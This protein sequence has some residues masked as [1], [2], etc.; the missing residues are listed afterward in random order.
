MTRSYL[1]FILIILNVFPASGQN[2]I[3]NPDFEENDGC[4]IYLSLIYEDTNP[5]LLEWFRATDGTPDHFNECADGFFLETVA[6]PENMFS[7]YQPTHSGDAYVGVVVDYETTDYREYIQGKLTDTLIAGEYYYFNGWLAPAMRVVE[8]G[9]ITKMMTSDAMGVYFSNNRITDFEEYD[10]IGVD[11]HI[12]NAAGNF[13][14]DPGAWT[15]MSGYY[16]AQGGE[17]W[18]TMGNFKPYTETNKIEMPGYLYPD[19]ADIEVYFFLDDLSLEHCGEKFLPDTMICQGETL[20]WNINLGEG[21]YLWS[22]GDTTRTITITTDGAYWLQFTDGLNT[23]IDT[24]IVTFHID[25]TFYSA[26]DITLCPDEIPFTLVSPATYDTYHWSN[27]YYTQSTNI[28]SEGTYYLTSRLNCNT[29]ID[30]FHVD[31]VN[32]PPDSMLIFNFSFCRVS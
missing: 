29:Y 3:S 16:L 6:I 25:S 4:P 19:D 7:N 17:T 18:I 13:V 20:I 30:T 22:T 11:A 15:E 12:S 21:D 28:A 5:S 32:T 27:G 24:G 8:G 1:I 9:D 31:A 2:L 14:L 26:M 10:T 23:H